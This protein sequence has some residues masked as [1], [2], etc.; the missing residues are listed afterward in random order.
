[1]TWSYGGGTNAAGQVIPSGGFDPILSLFESDG[2][3]MN[4]G[5]PGPCQG[6]MNVDPNTSMCG[7]VY[8][9]TTL[10]FPGGMWLAGTYTVALTENPNSSLGNLS[11]GFFDQQVLGYGPGTNFTCQ[12]GPTG[13]QGDP[14][15]F[16]VTDPFCSEWAPV[17]RNGSWAVDILNVD[18]AS[19]LGTPEPGTC[20]LTI[21]GLGLAALAGYRRRSVSQ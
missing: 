16:P 15:T 11:D 2:T 10:S 4:P 8:Y 20:A 12:V 6:P 19:Q 5:V 14:S 17:E 7:D 13:F 1:M 21:L 18:S 3:G 9:P